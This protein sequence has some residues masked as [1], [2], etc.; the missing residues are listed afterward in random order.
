MLFRRKSRTRRMMDWMNAMLQS[1][2]R[3]FKKIRS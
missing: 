1:V 2:L 3:W